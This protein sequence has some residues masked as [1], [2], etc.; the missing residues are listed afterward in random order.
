MPEVIRDR[1]PEFDKGRADLL[2]AMGSLAVGEARKEDNREAFSS[3]GKNG[4]RRVSIEDNNALVN[5][6]QARSRCAVYPQL[7]SDKVAD[8]KDS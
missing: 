2:D 6:N 5:V 3:K 1:E 8:C 7:A 4:M